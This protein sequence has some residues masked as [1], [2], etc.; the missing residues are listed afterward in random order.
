M[1]VP[2]IS[3]NQK[4]AIF[5]LGCFL[6]LAG[7]I[8]P[9]MGYSVPS[10]VPLGLKVPTTLLVFVHVDYYG[11]A[12]AG[13]K[14][15]FY[16]KILE[17]DVQKAILTEKITD[18]SGDAYLD[19]RTIYD[20]SAYPPIC[21]VRVD[22]THVQTGYQETKWASG[23]PKGEATLL[24]SITTTPPNG[25]GGGDGNGGGPTPTW[26]DFVNVLTIPGIILVVVSV[27][28]PYKKRE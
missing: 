11:L 5:L 26:K 23:P 24:F 25:D 13:A 17:G 14:V 12:V 9:L 10:V 18:A 3:T 20:D 7:L 27:V 8:S 6:V 19:A 16:E 28:L 2:A 21:Y 4:S 22:V 1:K 15:V